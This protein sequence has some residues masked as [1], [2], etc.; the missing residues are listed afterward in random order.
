MERNIM[1]K[2]KH[3]K[4]NSLITTAVIMNQNN[5]QKMPHYDSI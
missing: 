5:T 1:K 4:E 3:L 2:E